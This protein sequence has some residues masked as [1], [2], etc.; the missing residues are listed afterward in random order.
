MRQENVEASGGKT[1]SIRLLGDAGAAVI[2]KGQWLKLSGIQWKTFFIYPVVQTNS[3]G[4][5]SV[6]I[7]GAME[8]D[9]TDQ[10]ANTKYK[11]LA[12]LNAGS[13]SLEW[14]PPWPYVRAEVKVAGPAAIQ[15]GL[16]GIGI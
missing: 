4:A 1:T 13:P 7:H 5:V 14:E 6:E 8:L 15:A 10:D 11:V 16:Y 2:G 9:G 3:Y 12:T